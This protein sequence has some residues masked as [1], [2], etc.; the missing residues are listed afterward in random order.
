MRASTS[1]SAVTSGGPTMAKVL[2]EAVLDHEGDPQ[3][4]STVVRNA[5][6]AVEGGAW[7]DEFL[8]DVMRF[9]ARRYPEVFLSDVMLHGRTESVPWRFFTDHDDSDVRRF[10]AIH[11][12]VLTRPA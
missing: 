6:L 9:V 10:P 11:S 2:A 3:L 12:T 7:G 4:A 5:R 1:S 8:K